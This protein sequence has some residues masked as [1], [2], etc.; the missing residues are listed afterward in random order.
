[1]K[2]PADIP[3][4]ILGSQSPR[5]RAL[6]LEAG[7]RFEAVAPQTDETPPPGL[8]AQQVASHL[9]R[10]KLEACGEWLDH[11]LVL[12]ADTLVHQGNRLLGK[13]ADAE[14]ARH[15]LHSLAGS[16][17]EVTTAVCLGY[18]Q[19]RHTLT[20]TTQVTFAD[21]H[22]EEINYYISSF[23]PYDK[24]G[25]YGIQEWIGLIGIKH[26]AGSYTNVVGLPMHETYRALQSCSSNWLAG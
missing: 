17:H 21:L 13:P 8:E 24:A 12:T 11:K 10:Q 16:I 3:F 14:E 15:M 23:K 5:R 2:T 1:M 4:F 26:I 20:V 6:L 18:R 9:A 22:E 19:Q 25:A 7:L